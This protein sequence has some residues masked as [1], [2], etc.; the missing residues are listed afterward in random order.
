MTGGNQSRPND[1]VCSC[2]YR[3]VHPVSRTPAHGQAT[4]RQPTNWISLLAMY[5]D[6][7]PRSSEVNPT[8]IDPSGQLPTAPVTMSINASHLRCLPQPRPL[9]PLGVHDR[10]PLLKR[11]L[12]VRSL[13]DQRFR[14]S[15]DR[16]LECAHTGFGLAQKITAATRTY[17]CEAR[18]KKVCR[19]ERSEKC[20][21]TNG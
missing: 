21:R 3:G 16:R 2:L 1:I 20:S 10:P 14:S 4:G 15:A 18:H 5:S 6:H 17:V 8:S 13:T 7:A 9:L 19:E 11:S 12:K